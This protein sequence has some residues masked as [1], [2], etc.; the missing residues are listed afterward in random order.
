MIFA[1]GVLVEDKLV[2]QTDPIAVG[3]PRIAG[4]QEPP[5]DREAGRHRRASSA[6]TCG[7]RTC[8]TTTSSTFVDELHA[9][10]ARKYDAGRTALLDRRREHRAR[11][12]VE[13]IL[14]EVPG[15]RAVA[16]TGAEVQA[17]RTTSRRR[18]PAST[19]SD[20]GKALNLIFRTGPASLEERAVVV[21]GDPRDGSTRRRASAPRRRGSRWSASACSTTSRRTGSC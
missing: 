5:R 20:D 8:S 10:A 17:G 1:G 15:H 9:R 4:D 16:P 14:T 7:P 13:L 19:V 18:H 3:Q 6:C 11:T 21:Q 12:S 2:L